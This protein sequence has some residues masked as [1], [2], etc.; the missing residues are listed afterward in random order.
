MVRNPFG[1][2]SKANIDGAAELSCRLQC[3]RIP[4]S[5]QQIPAVEWRGAVRFRH[6]DVWTVSPSH[7][8][9][10]HQ[11]KTTEST[12]HAFGRTRYV[13]DTG[14]AGRPCQEPP[15]PHAMTLPGFERGEQPCAL[16]LRVKVCGRDCSTG[17][18]NRRSRRPWMPSDVPTLASSRISAPVWG[19]PFPRAVAVS[20]R[21]SRNS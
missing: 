10:L 16:V 6:T 21:S 18:P 4:S 7:L 19:P 3:L 11:V 1:I 9:S 14:P 17:A 5:S 2:C 12:R 8:A 15:K 13:A 20:R